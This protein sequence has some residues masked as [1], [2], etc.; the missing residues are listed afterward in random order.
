M[1]YIKDDSFENCKDVA[2]DLPSSP[3]VSY[4]LTGLLYVIL[5]LF[6]ILNNIAE[7][8]TNDS[9]NVANTLSGKLDELYNIALK[10]FV[11][12]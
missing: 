3:L 11:T 12:G 10:K 4:E 8:K 1:E 5:L 2:D 9:T 6:D 7:Q